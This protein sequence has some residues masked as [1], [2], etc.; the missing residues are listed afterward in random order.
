MEHGWSGPPFDPT[1]L[2][3]HLGI[4]VVPT[5]DVG[6]ARTITLPRDQLQIEFNPNRSRDRV[7][8]SIAH[9]IAHWLFPDCGEAIRY[10]HPMREQ[11]SDAW[12]VEMLCN[13]GAAEFLMPLGSFPDLKNEKPTIDRVL[14]LRRQFQVSTEAVLLRIVQETALACAMF[15]ASKGRAKEEPN[16]YRLDYTFG[17]RV[18]RLPVRSGA[19]LPPRTVIAECNAIGFTAKGK[20]RWSADETIHV[21]AVAVPPYPGEMF[22]RVVGVAS[23]FQPV[24]A[25]PVRITY[26][27]GDATEPRVDRNRVIAHVVNDKTPNWGAGFGLAVR[28]KWPQVQRAFEEWANAHRTEFRLG[29]FYCSAADDETIVYQMICQ[30]G[31][32]SERVLRLQYSSLKNCLEQLAEFAQ[33]KGATVHMPRIGAGFGGGSWGL[34]EQ[35]TDEILCARG[36]AVTVYDLPDHRSEQK[37]AQPGLFD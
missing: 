4:K 24:D 33:K 12:Q 19:L 37:K 11:R 3:E 7:R 8:F 18:W 20:E 14:E 26:L 17:S 30:H 13:I 27:V 36:V 1:K 23:P 34:I 28:K 2:A 10:R 32:G 31:Y 25:G 15:A 9:E 29:N 35:M 22:P 21:E 5:E 16:R 6:D